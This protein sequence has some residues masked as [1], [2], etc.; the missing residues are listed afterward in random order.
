MDLTLWQLEAT[1]VEQLRHACELEA[2]ND[3]IGH[4]DAAHKQ[5]LRDLNKERRLL[6]QT[7]DD[8]DGT[9]DDIMAAVCRQEQAIMELERRMGR[10]EDKQ[11]A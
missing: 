1:R 8:L 7:L 2:L 3:R 10:V 11:V 6:E 9:Q 4:T 5:L